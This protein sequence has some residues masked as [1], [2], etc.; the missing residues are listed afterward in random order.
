MKSMEPQNDLDP[1]HSDLSSVV[2]NDVSEASRGPARGLR[3]VSTVEI[4]PSEDS[5]ALDVE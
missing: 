3:L 2:S 5:E 1:L 4:P